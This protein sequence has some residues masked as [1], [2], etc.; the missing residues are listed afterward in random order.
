MELPNWLNF[1]SELGAQNARCL[2]KGS[3]IKEGGRALFLSFDRREGAANAESQLQSRCLSARE[4]LLPT[5]L[6]ETAREGRDELL[7]SSK[8]TFGISLKAARPAP[9]GF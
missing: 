2:W 7:T 9:K 8:V 6:P 4:M 5:R 1:Y 3:S